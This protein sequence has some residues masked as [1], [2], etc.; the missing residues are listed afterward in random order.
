MP[1]RLTRTEVERFAGAVRALL[2]DADA[3]LSRDGR[4][5]WE[6]VLA[7]LEAVLGEPSSLVPGG[8]DVRRIPPDV[9]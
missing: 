3:R 1:E 5:R 4:L 2:A 6:G 9:P 8:R 7:G